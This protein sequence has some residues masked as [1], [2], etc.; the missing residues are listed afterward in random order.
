VPVPSLPLTGQG[1]NVVGKIAGLTKVVI[2]VNDH[3]DRLDKADVKIDERL[4]RLAEKVA[5]LAVVLSEIS[6]QMKSIEKRL[7]EKDKLVAVTIELEVLKATERLPTEVAK[8]SV[9]P[10]A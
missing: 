1:L 7:E 6:G 10:L 5:A 4:E 2:T 8:V 3:L 9:P